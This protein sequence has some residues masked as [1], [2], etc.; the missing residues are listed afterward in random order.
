MFFSKVGQRSSQSSWKDFLSLFRSLSGPLLSPLL[1]AEQGVPL[2]LPLTCSCHPLLCHC[3]A[4]CHID[5]WRRST[6][7]IG[8]NFR[9]DCASLGWDPEINALQL[10]QKFPLKIKNSR[11]PAHGFN[12]SR[13]FT[14]F[15]LP[16]H[17]DQSVFFILVQTS[18]KSGVKKVTQFPWWT[19]TGKNQCG[20]GH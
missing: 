15:L 13:N 1:E 7:T 14:S 9:Q 17:V 16:R 3:H 5:W 19:Q 2:L 10:P 20:I 6:A 4:P 8:A 18:Q 11:P 12:I